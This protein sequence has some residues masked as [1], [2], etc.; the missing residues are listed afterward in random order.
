MGT[1]DT[2]RARKPRKMHK[3]SRAN[4]ACFETDPQPASVLTRAPSF[5]HHTRSPTVAR[6]CARRDLPRLS[7]PLETRNPP[8]IDADVHPSMVRDEPALEEYTENEP[9]RRERRKAKGRI[10]LAYCF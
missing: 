7:L 1:H 2:R 9:G 8:H 3:L 6:H 5:H 4:A 10:E